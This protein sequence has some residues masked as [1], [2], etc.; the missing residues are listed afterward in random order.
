MGEPIVSRSLWPLWR[1]TDFTFRLRQQRLWIID[2]PRLHHEM[3]IA[4]VLDI[5]H[6]IPADDE[7]VC[8]LPR[9][10][11]SQLIRHAERACAVDRCDLERRRRWNSC[12]HKRLKL[13]MRRETG[14]ELTRA[15]VVGAEG[16]QAAGVVEC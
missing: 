16:E 10:E 2:H 12:D 9:L 1:R 6:G 5:R 3:H 15:R 11:G 13:P 7:Q 8:E 14:E 4:R